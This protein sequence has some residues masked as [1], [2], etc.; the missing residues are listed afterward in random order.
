MTE[1]FYSLLGICQ[2]AR[3]LVSGSTVCEKAIR[4]GK[5]KLIIISEEASEE[6][7]NKYK[8]F[9]DRYKLPLVKVA[10]KEQLGRSI[11]KV[12]RTVIVITDSSLSKLLLDEIDTKKTCAGV[13]S[14]GEN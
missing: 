11:G 6:T 3:K 2:K 7:V 1:K 4:T 8:R 5:A 14:N 12:S 9:S 13:S 10:S